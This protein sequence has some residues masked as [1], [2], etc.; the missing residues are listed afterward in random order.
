MSTQQLRAATAAGKEP[1]GF[2]ELIE[3]MKPEIARALPR[4]INPERMA[5]IAVTEFRKAPKLGEC[6]VRSVFGAIITLSQLGL[7]PGVLGQAYLVPYKDKCTAVPGWQ[8]LAD[9][10]ARAGRASV[11]TGAV[12]EGDEFD[13]AFG[14][15]P[16][17]THRPSD[18][19][20]APGPDKLTYV[21]AVGRIKGAEW[22]VIDVWSRSKVTKHRD[23]FNKVG[24]QHY[25]FQHF[26]MYA[27]KVVL[28]Q[29]I[30]YMPKSV[31]LQNAVK[32]EEASAAGLTIDLKQAAAGWVP[33]TDEPEGGKQLP[34]IAEAVTLVQS[35][36]TLKENEEVYQGILNS[37]AALNQKL[38]VEIEGAYTDHKTALEQKL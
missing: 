28:L 19:D 24:N 15:R 33:S 17:I 9:L 37:F 6:D 26:E 31:E 4:H 11:W 16:H 38:P 35:T 8:G 3:A 29:V 27:R 2:L 13:Y 23:R 25:S 36:K 12:F 18:E 21:Y 20:D 22:P 14:D 5:R 34:T 30:K 10:V 7:E 1:R 32:L